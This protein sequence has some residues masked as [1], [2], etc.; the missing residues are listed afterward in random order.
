MR[1]DARYKYTD[2]VCLICS[3]G[4]RVRNKIERKS[5]PNRKGYKGAD[6]RATGHA[7]S[8]KGNVLLYIKSVCIFY[9]YDHVHASRLILGLIMK[10][11]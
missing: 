2:H 7:E 10:D 5:S 1:P 11:I 9:D 3:Y 4:N 8:T 6:K